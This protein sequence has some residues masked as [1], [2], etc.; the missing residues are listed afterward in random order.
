MAGIKHTPMKV[1]MITDTVGGVWTYCMELCRGLTHVQ[2]HLVTAG[3]KLNE[4]QRA[5]VESLQN[6]VVHETEY[7]LEWMENPWNDIDDSGEWLLELEKVLRPDLVHLNSYSYGMLPF[8]A[9]KVIVAHSDVF[10]WWQD[11]KGEMP[12]GGWNEYYYR[13]KQGLEA[14]DLVIAP[15][16]AMKKCIQEIYGVTSLIKVIY[17]GRSKEMFHSRSKKSYI[18]CMGRVWDEGKNVQLLIKAAEKIDCDIRIAGD[19]QFEGNLFEHYSNRIQFLG[20]L[21]NN[22]IAAELSEACLYVHF[23]SYRADK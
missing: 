19:Q 3:A 10:S 23:I 16:R 22:S 15:S 13:V 7:K 1:L 9:P 4:G 14:A 6:V 5:E 2:F 20:R 12:Q 17:N 8:N 21:K 11:V 18:F